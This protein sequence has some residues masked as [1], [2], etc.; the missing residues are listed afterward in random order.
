LEKKKRERE[1]EITMGDNL[2][3]KKLDRKRISLKQRH[4]RAY[5]KRIAKEQL[6]Q[7]KL[8]KR[9]EFVDKFSEVKLIRICKALLKVLK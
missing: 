9:D 1:V 7:L 5:L 8:M 6:E 2:K 4:E 3:K